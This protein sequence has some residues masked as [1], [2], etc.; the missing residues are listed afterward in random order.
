MKK[1]G[2]VINIIKNIILDI[3]IVILCITIVVGILNK[4]KPTSIFGYYFFTVMSGSMQ[5]ELKV[6]DNII[7]KQSNNYEVGDIVTYKGDKSYITHRIVKIEDNMITTKG[8]DNSDEDPAFDKSNI[9]GKVVFKSKYLNFVVKYR[10]FIIFAI[11]LIY[12]FEML[13]TSLGKK[14]KDSETQNS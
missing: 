11:I 7:V 10:V 5:P 8:D 14:E 4:N 1:F 3:I 9:L 12:L 2:K 6:N 13:I